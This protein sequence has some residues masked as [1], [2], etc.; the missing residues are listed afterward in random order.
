MS[1]A[2]RI[3]GAAGAIGLAL[4]IVAPRTSIRV[5]GLVA[6]IAGW[7][8]LA[9]ELAPEGHADLYAVTAAVGVAVAAGLAA[10][11]VR[12]P[13]LL[14]LLA[15]ASVPFGVDVDVGGAHA[16]LL[17]PLYA[18]CAGAALALLWRPHRERDL[19]L[20]AWPLALLVAFA[21]LSLLWSD[22]PHG[23]GTLLARFVLPLAVLALAL[24]R[25]S[26]RPGWS[27]VL[28]VELVGL[29]VGLAIAGGVQY[30]GRDVTAG[31]G[32]SVVSEWYYPVGP[33][34]GDPHDYGRF[35]VIALAAALAVAVRVRDARAWAPAAVAA[36]VVWLG[37][38]PSFSEPAFAALAVAAAALVVAVWSARA[39]FPAA[40]VLLVG[41]AVAGSFAAVRR[42]LLDRPGPDGPATVYGAVR[43]ALD[44]PFA[45]VGLGAHAA[46]SSVATAAAELGAPG[47]A[48]LGAT[49]VAAFAALRARRGAGV[50]ALVA[51][52]LAIAVDSTL[53]GDLLRDPLFWGT[54]GLAA[55]ASR[56]PAPARRRPAAAERRTRD[57]PS[58]LADAEP[59]PVSAS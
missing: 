15:L 13:W 3:A 16:R 59:H 5:A 6:C 49:F 7:G 50:A 23:G 2:A 27:A 40:V 18:V 32:R 56:P 11:F 43:T 48:L 14:A 10:L 17:L 38:V 25:L 33:A 42:D 47:L 44:H 1:E 19:G 4:A 35:L 31:F 55:A 21:G 45:G 46:A 52:L 58:R 34:F 29:G 20:V 39:L 54:L 36:I 30:L 8:V 57:E 37:L 51:A 12:E 9:L 26:W 22:D 53:R 28:A 41:T 24:A